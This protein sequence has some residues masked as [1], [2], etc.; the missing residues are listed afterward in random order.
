MAGAV[1]GGV[2]FALAPCNIG[3]GVGLVEISSCTKST[4]SVRPT[5]YTMVFDGGGPMSRYYPQNVLDD[6]NHLAYGQGVDQKHY[7]EEVLVI[8]PW[9]TTLKLG[10][11]R[12][13]GG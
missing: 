7:M 3:R 6:N 2:L 13:T 12:E 8:V 9:N 1:G 11:N 4:R 5:I 10:H